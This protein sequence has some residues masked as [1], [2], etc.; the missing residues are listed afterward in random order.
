MKVRTKQW[1]RRVAG[2]WG[3]LGLVLAGL[4]VGGCGTTEEGPETRPVGEPILSEAQLREARVAVSF[5]AHVQPI[6]E[7]RCVHCHNQEQMPGK[8]NLET[9]AAALRDG[10]RIVPGKSEQSI[11]IIAL[12]TGNHALSMPAVGTAPP[13]EEIEVLRAW[14]DAGAPWPA[15]VTLRSRD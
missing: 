7:E 11:M 12:T 1:R 6:L 3:S 13:P 10:R 2:G 15:G 9:R 4:L 5:E 8:F 14:I